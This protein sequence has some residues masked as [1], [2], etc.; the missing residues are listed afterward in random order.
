MEGEEGP[1]QNKTCL[2]GASRGDRGQEGRQETFNP[3]KLFI[4]GFS[5]V[6]CLGLKSEALVVVRAAEVRL[7]GSTYCPVGVGSGKEC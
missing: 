6:S 4:P 5:P 7:T 2:L 3:G 1:G